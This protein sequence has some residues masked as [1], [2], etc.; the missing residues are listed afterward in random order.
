[1]ISEEKVTKLIELFKKNRDATYV[2]S[3]DTFIT[4]DQLDFEAYD[5][6]ETTIELRGFVEQ[7][8]KEEVIDLVAIMLFGRGDF[9][10]DFETCR[11][12]AVSIYDNEGSPAY[13]LAKKY[14][15]Q[16]LEEGLKKVEQIS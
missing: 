2:E 12:H 1:M 10:D 15:D 4:L 5:N 9:T 7:L 11:L 14:L 3:K 8:D 16:Y 13:L 6:H